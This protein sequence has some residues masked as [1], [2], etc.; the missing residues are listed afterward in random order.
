M[1]AVTVATSNQNVV[2][3]GLMHIHVT[4]DYGFHSLSAIIHN[5]KYNLRIDS[6][7]DTV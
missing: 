5:I 6:D 2:F 7:I 1:L 3:A 4:Q